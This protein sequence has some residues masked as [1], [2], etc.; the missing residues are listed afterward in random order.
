MI[1]K[2]HANLDTSTSQPFQPS[3]DPTQRWG[4]WM[5]H[6]YYTLT[7][8]QQPLRARMCGFGDKDR[9]P[10][11]PAAVAKM[12]VHRED[13]TLIEPDD[14]DCSF[15]LVT[16]DLWSA[17]GKREMN[18]V[19]H[20]SSSN[21]RYMPASAGK[22]RKR[23]S[24]ASDTSRG[25]PSPSSPSSA[26]ASSHQQTSVEQ[27]TSTRSAS[28]PQPPYG[29][30]TYTYAQQ[31]QPVPEQMTIAPYNAPVNS[32]TGWSASRSTAA[33]SP[34]GEGWQAGPASTYRTWPGASSQYQG[35]VGGQEGAAFGGP[36]IDP[37]HHHGS[38]SS[39]PDA[40]EPAPGAWPHTQQQST[41][42]QAHPQSRYPDQYASSPTMGYESQAEYGPSSAYAQPSYYQGNYP[43]QSPTP[44]PANISPSARH[45]YTRTLVGPLSANA[46]RLVDDQH[47]PGIFFLF[48]DLSVPSGCAYAS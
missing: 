46:C 26:S 3:A 20:P 7:V 21:E 31:G 24:N 29:S 17:D 25:H 5:N 13:N 11:A 47:K 38:A 6:K 28:Y 19:L 43:P 9:R 2:Q 37:R 40:R 45:T 16:V 8:A 35:A 42:E 30:P 15:F 33:G 27:Q 39:Q 44:P 23:S 18:L 32:S 41:P 10:L 22:P 14:L 4:S 36:E 12:I 1:Q 34:P 48:Q